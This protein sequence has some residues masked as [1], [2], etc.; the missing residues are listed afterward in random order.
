MYLYRNTFDSFIFFTL[1]AMLEAR[2]AA[3]EVNRLCLPIMVCHEEDRVN[4]MTVKQKC[5]R[6]RELSRAPISILKESKLDKEKVGG[7]CMHACICYHG[8]GWL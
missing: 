5:E 3:V 1:G 4:P 8:P 7:K 2:G 6:F